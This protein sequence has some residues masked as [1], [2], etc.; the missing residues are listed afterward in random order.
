MNETTYHKTKLHLG[1]RLV[2]ALY[3][4]H[5][6][7]AR[8]AEEIY[9]LRWHDDPDKLAMEVVQVPP[10]MVWTA[11]HND[12]PVAVFGAYPTHPKV[13]TVFAFA[14]DEWAKCVLTVTK[15][16]KRFMIPAIDATDAIRVQC[17]AMS[18][19]DDARKW[20]KILGAV[21]GPTLDFY[22]KN[23]QD[24]TCY[25]WTRKNQQEQKNVL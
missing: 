20:L 8:D 4:A 15:H 1:I 5:R 21:E 24:F 10:D 7:R 2:D 22:G 19:H 12:L 25:S 17:W 16:I 23:G 11:T 9:A 3:I 13:W 18:T 6:L 14:T